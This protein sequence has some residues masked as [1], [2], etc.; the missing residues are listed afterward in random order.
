M[1]ARPPDFARVRA[2]LPELPRISDSFGPRERHSWA[3]VAWSGPQAAFADAAAVLAAVFE[4]VRG[5]RT[6]NALIEPPDAHEV[7]A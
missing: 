6:A 5:S 4:P 1:T 7:N 2:L 3:S